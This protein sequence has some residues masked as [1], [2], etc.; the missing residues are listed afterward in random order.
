LDQ[1]VRGDVSEANAYSGYVK[2][3]DFVFLGFCVGNVGGSIEEQVNGAFDMMEQ[4]LADAGLTLDR[5]VKIDV[6]LRDVWNLP[7]VEKV[8]RQ[9][10]TAG[11]PAR[12]T[13]A[14]EFAHIGG[15]E[16]VHVQIDGIAYAASQTG[17]R[18]C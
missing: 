17:H 3:G 5:L 13:I 10:F 16:G 2:A 14:S 4:R 18:S 8:I 7:V 15:S 6:L 9:R 1:I 12:T 11:F